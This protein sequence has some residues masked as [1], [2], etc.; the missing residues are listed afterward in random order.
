MTR[1]RHSPP[2]KGK[3]GKKSCK[4]KENIRMMNVPLD[5][6]GRVWPQIPRHS[7]SSNISSIGIKGVWA[8]TQN[9][10]RLVPLLVGCGLGKRQVHRLAVKHGS[11][12]EPLLWAIL[13]VFSAPYVLHVKTFTLI[14]LTA[15]PT[16]FRE[17]RFFPLDLLAVRRVA[18]LSSQTFHQGP[19]LPRS[20]RALSDSSWQSAVLECGVSLRVAGLRQPTCSSSS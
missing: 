2:Q 8:S 1:K 16:S 12:E 17:S 10:G 11:S 20:S 14:R 3:L 13:K 6:Q 15:C 7:S 18:R 4:G 9:Q 19:C 5:S